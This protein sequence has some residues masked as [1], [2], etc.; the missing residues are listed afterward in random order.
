MST[1]IRE[2]LT[3]E[4]N[5]QIR[6]LTGTSVIFSKLIADQVGQH[7]TDLECLD[8]LQLNGR[9]TAGKLA[10]LTGLTTGA[11]TAMVDRLEK[12]G[13]VWRERDP[14]DRRKVIVVPNYPKIDQEVA[15]YS[16]SIGVALE[17]LS[18]E[19]SVDELDI[20]LRFLKKAN[21][22]GK[23]EIAKLRLTGRE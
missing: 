7:P 11:I 21:A 18:D 2:E 12:V 1:L 6:V 19:F 16:K 4:L 9:C 5:E 15:P 22:A 13:Y 20:I 14:N 8:F 3:Q 17:N 10:E 23:E